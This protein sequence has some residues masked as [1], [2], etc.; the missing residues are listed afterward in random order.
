MRRTGWLIKHRTRLN[1]LAVCGLCLALLPALPAQGQDKA[2]QIERSRQKVFYSFSYE[3]DLIGSGQDQQ[4][5]SG[6]RLTRFKIG[7]NIPQVIDSI[8]DRVPTFDINDSTGIFYSIGQNLYTPADIERASD[9]PQDRPWAGWLYG[10]AGLYTLTGDHIDELEIT[11]GVVG[12]DALG[13]QTQ[14]FI[15]R[16]ITDSP[17]PRGWANQLN[18]E[19]G[20]IL[21]WARRWPQKWTKDFGNNL[22]LAAAPHF[23]VS[24]GNIYTYAGSGM[25]LTLGPYQDTLQETPAPR[26]PGHARQRVLHHARSGLELVC[27]CRAGRPR[28]GPQYLS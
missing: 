22:Q 16:H 12:P 17:T 27:L 26:A 24:L 25:S 3:N 23:T 20:L 2:A 5:T 10:S 1:R 21:S 4:Y 28:Y 6:L 19:P 11:L 14:K 18:N 15:H 13:E 8:A 9:N 7:A